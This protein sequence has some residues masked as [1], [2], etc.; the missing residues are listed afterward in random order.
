MLPSNFFELQEKAKTRTSYLVF[1]F[2]VALLATVGCVTAI[3]IAAVAI[4]FPKM[5]AQLIQD[6]QYALGIAGILAFLITLVS[7]FKVLALKATGGRGVLGGFPHRIIYG[8]SSNEQDRMLKNVVEE[9]SI[10]SGVPM[11]I[12]A[13]LEDERVINAF[14]AGFH[15]KDSVI[16]VTQ[17]TLDQLSR[18]QLQGV[19]AHEFSHLLNK[20]TSMNLKIMGAIH[21]LLILSI[22]GQGMMRIRSGRSSSSRDNGGMI[23]VLVGLGF[24]LCGMIG[25]FF[26]SIIQAAVSRQ[27]EFLADASAVQ[28]TRNPLGI[29]SALAKIMSAPANSMNSAKA[30]EMSHF[31]F[32]SNSAA[33]F[34]THPPLTERIRAIAPQLLRE[35]LSEESNKG[36]R[37]HPQTATAMD[38][39]T[40]KKPPSNPLGMAAF[41]ISQMPAIEEK[42]SP[43]IAIAHT[44]TG[45][46]FSQDKATFESQRKIVSES[47]SDSVVQEGLKIAKFLA[48][49]NLKTR[50][51]TLER[52]LSQIQAS[53]TP[54]NKKLLNLIRSLILID[55]K[56][57]FFEMLLWLLA[58]DAATKR[59]A[60]QKIRAKNPSENFREA[61]LLLKLVS[62]T[63]KLEASKADQALHS[64]LKTYWPAGPGYVAGLKSYSLESMPL[65]LVGEAVEELKFS[66]EMVRKTFMKAALDLASS[67]S[68]IEE[69]EW[70]L[71]RAFGILLECPVPLP[72]PN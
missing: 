55:K 54:D 60:Y 59:P 2:L 7:I 58:V 31:F 48:Y 29:G 38:S 44:V 9:M 28:F 46:L 69:K 14:A 4:K 71:L 61:T 23:L 32:F 11:P 6:P 53:P 15:S 63:S 3:V 41:A 35:G 10:A 30:A 18:D 33:L 42:T 66:S 40:Q 36:S 37:V 1:L 39:P 27:R 5:Q 13:V 8:V 43:T 67:N 24:F 17:G 16:A 52:T 34:A 51:L 62:D 49:A 56:I 25:K 65:K 70:V 57:S 45:I 50:Y 26:S 22:I 47:Y 64:A 19:V 72:A 68:L 21:G 12:I 20:D